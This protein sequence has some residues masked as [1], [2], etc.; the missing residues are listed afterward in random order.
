MTSSLVNTS[1]IWV[2]VNTRFLKNWVYGETFTF[3][4]IL[5][6]DQMFERNRNH[7]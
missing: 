3:Y 5:G 2:M 6:V 4:P 1:K 7:D